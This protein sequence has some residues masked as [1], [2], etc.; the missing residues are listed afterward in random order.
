MFTVEFDESLINEYLDNLKKDIF[1]FFKNRG[2][3]GEKLTF[4]NRETNEVIE[5]LKPENYVNKDKFNVDFLINNKVYTVG[6]LNLSKANSNIYVIQFK[7]T[8]GM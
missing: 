3:T 2:N 6:E 1:S 7:F 5:E 4:K 8:E